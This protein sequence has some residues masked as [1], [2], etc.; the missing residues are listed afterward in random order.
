M[1]VDDPFTRQL[2]DSRSYRSERFLT[3][4]EY[5][6]VCRARPISQQPV[7]S[8][9]VQVQGSMAADVE[10]ETMRVLDR[11]LVSIKGTEGEIL[12]LAMGPDPLHLDETMLGH[13]DLLWRECQYITSIHVRQ[14]E[15]GHFMDMYLD[16]VGIWGLIAK[17]AWNLAG[18]D[19]RL[20]PR[21]ASG[22]EDSLELID[23]ISREIA[24]ALSYILSSS[25]VP[26]DHV[27]VDE[28]FADYVGIKYSLDAHMGEFIETDRRFY[29]F[30]KDQLRSVQQRATHNRG[31]RVLTN[32][33]KG[34]PPVALK[35]HQAA[36]IRK[37]VQMEDDPY[38]RGGVLAEEMGLGKTII[39]LG[40]ICYKRASEA[41]ALKLRPHDPLTS[42]KLKSSNYLE[43]EQ[44]AERMRE[45]VA[46]YFPKTTLY[47]TTLHR[48]FTS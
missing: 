47:I 11:P 5:R 27:L 1:E 10:V 17:R 13:V 22:E 15:E 36:A 32:Q 20:L 39:A 45:R 12:R 31:L 25:V 9:P 16:G 48:V 37:M 29:G 40:L 8:I 24:K 23:A 2:K 6:D 41:P 14:R 38:L 19:I 7:V 21:R 42:D 46:Y 30:S 35:D 28:A 33:A 3:E 26:E 4:A 43:V 18:F 34:G 44:A